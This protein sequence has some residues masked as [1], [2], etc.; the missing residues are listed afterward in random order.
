MTKAEVTIKNVVKSCLVL[1]KKRYLSNLRE[2]YKYSKIT[3][4]FK[5]LDF[6]EK[7]RF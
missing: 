5:G 2:V 4:M 7:L 6:V 3:R 1:S